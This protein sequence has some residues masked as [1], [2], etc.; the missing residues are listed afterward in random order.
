M[1]YL[2]LAF[3]LLIFSFIFSLVLRGKTQQKATGILNEIL[4]GSLGKMRL[5]STI[6]V[7]I[8]KILLFL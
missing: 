3:L 6:A 4:T 8:Y 5:E 1:E 2:F 7:V